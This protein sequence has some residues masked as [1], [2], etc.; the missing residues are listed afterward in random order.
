MLLLLLL[1]PPFLCLLPPNTRQQFELRSQLAS[2]LLSI[3]TPVSIDFILL[4]V[5]S[6]TTTTTTARVL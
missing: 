3:E 1:R 4:Q 5:S 2:Y 6:T